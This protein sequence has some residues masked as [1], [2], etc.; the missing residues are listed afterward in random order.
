VRRNS[1]TE[2]LPWLLSLVSAFIAAQGGPLVWLILRGESTLLLYQQVPVLT[3][4][5]YGAYCCDSLHDILDHPPLKDIIRA[6]SLYF[7]AQ[8]ATLEV[9]RTIAENPHA[10]VAAVLGGGTISSCGFVLLNFRDSMGGRRTTSVF[11]QPPAAFKLAYMLAF[12]Y[13]CVLHGYIRAE[14]KGD[15]VYTQVMRWRQWLCALYCAYTSFSYY[16]R[17][18]GDPLRYLEFLLLIVFR[19]DREA[20]Y[21]L[22]GSRTSQVKSSSGAAFMYWERRRRGGGL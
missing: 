12:I 11:E 22:H 9:D 10:F 13:A 2:R 15:D 14:A 4:V 21:R 16:I 6:G 7:V 19:F 17:R 20:I 5:W 8:R 18:F 1:K 3:L